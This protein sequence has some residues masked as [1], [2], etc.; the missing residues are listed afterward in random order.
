MKRLSAVAI[1]LLTAC[2]RAGA[3]G[4]SGVEGRVLLGPQCPVVTEASPCPD[5]PI[6]TKVHVQTLQGDEVAVVES[7]PDGMFR[8]ALAPGQYVLVAE[9]AG[10]AMSAKPT[11]VTVAAGEFARV[12]VLLDT[13][14]RDPVGEA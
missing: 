9:V 11:D 7:G 4:S 13:G 8:V 5:E 10:N 2:A 6:A 3:G 12:T 14:I 1:L